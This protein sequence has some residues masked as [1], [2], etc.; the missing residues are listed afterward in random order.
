MPYFNNPFSR[1]RPSPATRRNY[2]A[3]SSNNENENSSMTNF[4]RRFGESLGYN[5]NMINN[6]QDE[7]RDLIN[8]AGIATYNGLSDE[9]LQKGLKL[10]DKLKTNANFDQIF[11]SIIETNNVIFVKNNSAFSFFFG[12]LSLSL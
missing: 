11:Q 5:K 6:S 12:S 4:A 10:I 3:N 1:A 8:I 9:E 7:Q 2:K